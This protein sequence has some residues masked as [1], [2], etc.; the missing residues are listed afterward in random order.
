MT[1]SLLYKCDCTLGEGAFWHEARQSFFWVDIEGM[2]LHEY[3]IG[4]QK[5]NFWQFANR[6]SMIALNR[7]GEM[8]L[9]LQGGVA[10]FDLRTGNL[11]SLAEIEKENPNMRTNDGGI[12]A[13]GRLWIGT[14]HVD[15]NA[16]AG[17]LY[18]V[19]N[20]FLP[21]KKIENLTIPNGLTWS[22]DGKTMYHIDS[23]TKK[24]QAY[25]FNSATGEIIFERTAITIPEGDGFPDGMCIDKEGMLWIA[26]WDG[27]GV[28]RWN[29][30]NG[31]LLNK[32]EVPVPQVSS[33]AF[34]GANFDQ[35]FIT[36]ARENF[37]PSLLE[38][39]P[40]SGSVY[41]ASPGVKGVKKNL[42]GAPRPCLSGRLSGRQA[43]PL[44]KG[45]G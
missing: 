31:K 1:A 24:V 4:N 10:R 33:C 41:V 20:D 16:G 14:M 29:P 17:G 5:V 44:S 13:E 9:V 35:L 32:I 15:H 21:V 3:V 36:T 23:P 34:G 8:I 25:Y 22:L 2:R 11:V 39:Y 18:C 28:C 19:E 42:F 27:F 12:D 26:H 6:P 45:E 37:T 38:K 43:Q 40:D 30:E 7:Q